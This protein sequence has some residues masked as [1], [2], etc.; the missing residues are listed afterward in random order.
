MAV[1]SNAISFHMNMRSNAVG[2]DARRGM[3]GEHHMH[4]VGRHGEQRLEL[5]RN[6]LRSSVVAARAVGAACI[7]QGECRRG[8]RRGIV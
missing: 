2:G 4:L 8:R 6:W 3:V 7:E 5:L 1:V